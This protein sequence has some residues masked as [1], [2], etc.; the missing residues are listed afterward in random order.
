ML[1]TQQLT[2]KLEIEFPALSFQE[3]N[4]SNLWLYAY[5]PGF[6]YIVFK[7]SKEP[8]KVYEYSKV[9]QE[10]FNLLDKAKSKGSFFSMNIKNKTY[11]PYKIYQLPS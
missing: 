7:Q 11:F 1:T 9:S 5:K 10:I 6:L 2:S 8:I 4:S 3:A